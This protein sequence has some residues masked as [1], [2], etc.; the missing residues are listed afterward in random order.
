MKSKKSEN[1]SKTSN[2]GNLY[3]ISGPSGVGKGAV[4]AEVMRR[5]PDIK[6]SVSAT[7]RAPRLGETEGVSYFFVSQQKFEQMISRGEFLEYDRHFDNYYGT[8]S[9]YVYDM[10]DCGRDVIL[11]ID[12]AGA[13]EVKGK[14]PEA[15]LL[16]IMP[17]TME[18]L[19]KR[20]VC[21]STESAEQIKKRLQRVEE[22]TALQTRYDYVIVNDTVEKAADS[23]TEIIKEMNK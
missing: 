23:I 2:K 4:V 9:K 21:R 6:L 18:E 22:E 13:Q 15:K 8:P 5:L 1:K 12:I 7:T 3:I 16:F 11:E 17:P 10:L 20:L 14:Y 19:E